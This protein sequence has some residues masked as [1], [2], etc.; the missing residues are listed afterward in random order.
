MISEQVYLIHAYN[1]E[2][3]LSQDPKLTLVVLCFN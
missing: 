2:R 3:V 1:E